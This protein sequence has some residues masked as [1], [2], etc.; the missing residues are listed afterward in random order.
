MIIIDSALCSQEEEEERSD[1][2]NSFLERQAESTQLTI[3]GEFKV[4]DNKS[5]HAN[6]SEQ[7]VD[8]SSEKGV[9]DN[10]SGKEP[11]SNDSIENVSDKE[12][13]PTTKETKP[14]RIQIWTEIR[15]SLHAIENMMSI[16][17]KKK[18]NLSKDEQ[19]TG[20]GKP[21]PSIE[22]ARYIKGASEEDSEDEFYDV[23]RSDPNQDVP[24]S[25]SVSSNIGGASDLTPMESLF[26]WKEELEVLVRGGVP[27][28]LRGEVR[29][30]FLSCLCTMN[31][32]LMN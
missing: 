25:D 30:T 32:L 5:L 3:N 28:A 13:E 2:W 8:A 27:M 1:R 21:L 24:S 16:R 7:E 23:E 22:E 10:F 6:A 4:E 20:S 12:E 15:P 29:I 26:P 11:D 19:D 18:S 31:A 14:H 9:G 17:V